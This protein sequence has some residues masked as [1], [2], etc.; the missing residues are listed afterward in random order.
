M[1]GL[2]FYA[3]TATQMFRRATTS[4]NHAIRGSSS[5][6]AAVET[7][8]SGSSNSSQNALGQESKETKDVVNQNT[9]NVKKPKCR[10][11]AME[12]YV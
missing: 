6:A 4:V 2:R 12:I 11:I 5:N 10:L 7:A 9:E 3:N 1:L 8:A